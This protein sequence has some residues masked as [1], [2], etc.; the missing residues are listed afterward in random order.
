MRRCCTLAI[1]FDCAQFCHSLRF[2]EVQNPQES[3]GPRAQPLHSRMTFY[4]VRVHW[5]VSRVKDDHR[6]TEIAKVLPTIID[7]LPWNHNFDFS[8]SKY[9]SLCILSNTYSTFNTPSRKSFEPLARPTACAV[10]IHGPTTLRR[11]K[12]PLSKSIS[13]KWDSNSR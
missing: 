1:A 10:G 8:N 13:E 5:R 4:S 11:A 6:N 12:G 9:Q 7:L 2:Q 3:T